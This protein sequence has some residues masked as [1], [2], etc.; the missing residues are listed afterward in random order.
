MRSR[1]LEAWAAHWRKRC[2]QRRR[3]RIP[4]VL[5]LHLVAAMEESRRSDRPRPNTY[6]VKLPP[7]DYAAVADSLAALEVEL[8]EALAAEARRR[9]YLL[10]GPVKVEITAGQEGTIQVETVERVP[11]AEEQSD[12]EPTLTYTTGQKRRGAGRKAPASLVV[13]QGPDKGSSFALWGDKIYVG[14]RETN[15]VVL[16]D[17]GVSRVHL[18]LARTGAHVFLRDLKSLNGTRVN[19]ER[20][21]EAWLKP[22]DRIELGSTCLEYRE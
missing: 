2:V 13:L 19:G 12:L 9:N 6:V 21:T 15:H 14:R 1:L 7:A 18:E 17:P 8:Q 16:H 22:G 11:P 3:E 10:A 20:V 5:R 4:E